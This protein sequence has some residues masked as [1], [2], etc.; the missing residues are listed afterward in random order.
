MTFKYN[1]RII[2]KTARKLLFLKSKI[3]RSPI[4]FIDK[5]INFDRTIEIYGWAIF[6]DKINKI[7]IYFND[8]YLGKA[9]YGQHRKD[10]KEKYPFIN[11]SE[12]S[13]FYYKF[14]IKDYIKKKVI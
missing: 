3:L 10:I 2:I 11:N 14:Q 4:F 13:G 8:L 7:E 9:F 6:K 5:V 12:Y 1:K